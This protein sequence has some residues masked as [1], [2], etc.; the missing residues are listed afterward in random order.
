[1]S[2]VLNISI[3]RARSGR[4]QPE[5]AQ[6]HLSLAAQHSKEDVGWASHTFQSS[7]EAQGR[8]DSPLHSG[9]P[10]VPGAGRQR[11]GSISGL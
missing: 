10:W 4:K 5:T 6:L 7:M 11:L 3:N 2:Q 9:L 1:M 8:A